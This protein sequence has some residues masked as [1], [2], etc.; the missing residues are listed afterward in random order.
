MYRVPLFVIILLVGCQHPTP[1]YNIIIQGGTIYNGSGEAPFVADIGL[2]GDSI[3]AIGN[4]SAAQADITI[5][6][7]AKAVAPGFINMLSWATYSLLEDGKSQSD[8]RQGVTLEIFGEGWSM[9]PLSD[10]MKEDVIKRQGDIKFDIEWTTLGEYL[11]HLVDRGVSTNVASFVGATTVRIHELGYEDRP[12]TDDELDR[13]RNLV[14]VAMEE[15]AMG[16]GSSLIYAPA[17]YA[18]TRELIELS[19]VAA[20]YNGM[21]T[22]HLR[23]EGNQLLEAVDELITISREADIRAQ[24]YHLKAAGR[25]NWDK[26][27]TVFEKIETASWRRACYHC[28]YVHLYRRGYRI[29]C[30]HA[31]LGTRRGIRCLVQTLAR[32]G[33][34]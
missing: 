16:I 32:N 18:D 15:G 22:S 19:K 30:S 3:A 1:T 11:E 2:I 10:A 12:P 34:S 33:N 21:Y 26:L 24:I 9:G 23:S 29:R 28:R 17:F 4:L 13:M 27:D 20:E 14:R 7:T 8:I 25:S 31:S 6:A 5:D